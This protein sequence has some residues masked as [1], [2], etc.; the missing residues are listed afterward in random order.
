MPVAVVF[1]SSTA[2]WPE[3]HLPVGD[4]TWYTMADRGMDRNHAHHTRPSAP[5]DRQTQ[6]A[7]HTQQHGPARRRPVEDS[8]RLAARRPTVEA[9]RAPIP[10]LWLAEALSQTAQVVRRIPT[11]GCTRPDGSI[12]THT[13][14]SVLPLFMRTLHLALRSYFG[15]SGGWLPPPPSGRLPLFG[16]GEHSLHHTAGSYQI[17]T[18]GLSCTGLPP[19]KASVL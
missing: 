10:A 6:T 12:F 2:S 1:P 15:L 17:L 14:S 4:T 19:L 16:T 13:T 11:D 3:P 9:F 18:A 7:H 8:V 5:Y